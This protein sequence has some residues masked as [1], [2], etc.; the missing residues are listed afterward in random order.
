M[1]GCRQQAE[2][3]LTPDQIEQ[4]LQLRQQRGHLSPTECKA[5]LE[6][7]LTPDQI[8]QLRQL[9]QQVMD[10]GRQQPE[11]VLTPDQI[12]QLLQLR[13]QRGHL[14]P[15]ERKAQLEFLLTPDQIEQLGQLVG[16]VMGQGWGP[17]Q[18]TNQMP[19][20]PWFVVP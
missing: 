1:D 10:V 2:P 18:G 7:L 13:H 19:G 3:V 14:S 17:P 12:E 11:P 9:E 4:L 5:Q 20:P 16:Q 8:E 6:S 15:T